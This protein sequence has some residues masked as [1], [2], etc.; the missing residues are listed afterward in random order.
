MTRIELTDEEADILRVFAKVMP[1]VPLHLMSREEQHVVKR[2]VEQLPE[3]W[4]DGV[5]AFKPATSSIL[6]LYF[7][8]DGRYNRRLSE[9]PF[10]DDSYPCPSTK[11]GWTR[12]GN[13]PERGLTP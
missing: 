3:P 4:E 9:E 1:R 12:V 13:L 7:V 11:D 10:I 8:V 6:S 5:Y 2:I